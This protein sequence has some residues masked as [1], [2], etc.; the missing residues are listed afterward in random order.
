M[1]NRLEYLRQANHEHLHRTWKRAETGNMEGLT[2]EEKLLAKIVLEHD[3]YHNQFEIL[4]LIRDHKYDFR[5][6][7]NPLPHVIFHVVIENQLV[8]GEP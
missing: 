4:G 6:E 1:T 3:E 7:V 2:D 5:S 8:S